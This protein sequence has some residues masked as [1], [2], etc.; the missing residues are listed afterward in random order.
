MDPLNGIGCH[1]EHESHATHTGSVVWISCGDCH[2]TD[3]A[4]SPL[5]SA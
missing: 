2:D 3:N 4:K 5:P 1:G